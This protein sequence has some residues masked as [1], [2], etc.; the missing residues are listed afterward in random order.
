MRQSLPRGDPE[1]AALDAFATRNG[2]SPHRRGHVEP[3]P[4]ARTGSGKRPEAKIRALRARIGI[5]AAPH[6]RLQVKIEPIAESVCQRPNQPVVLHPLRNRHGLRRGFAFAQRQFD[7]LTNKPDAQFRLRGKGSDI[8]LRCQMSEDITAFVHLAVLH[9]ARL[10]VDLG[11][12]ASQPLHPSTTNNTA[13]S[14]DNSRSARST[15]RARATDA[16]SVEPSRSPEVIDEDASGNITRAIWAPYYD[17]KKKEFIYGLRGTN[18]FDIRQV[19]GNYVG[20]DCAFPAI[21]LA[22]SHVCKS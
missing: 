12:G 14:V 20:K 21:K 11:D 17:P 16:F 9:H 7:Q 19:L 5:E 8:E 22:M 13:R 1:R 3:R 2:P 4:R 6:S 10:A 18:P 15:S